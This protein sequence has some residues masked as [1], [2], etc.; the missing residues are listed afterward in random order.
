MHFSLFALFSS[1][2]YALS[3]TMN[4]TLSKKN[5]VL[6]LALW[7]SLISTVIGLPLLFTIYSNELSNLTWGNAVMSILISLVAVIAFPCF[8]AAFQKGSVVTTGIIANSYPAV[9]I[10]LSIFILGESPSAVQILAIMTI[11]IGVF[12]ASSPE[13]TS[14]FFK[15]L[16]KG[17]S[18]YA[19][20]TML[21]WGIYYSLIKFPVDEIGPFI[22]QYSAFVTMFVTFSIY[23]VF[24]R[25]KRAIKKPILLWLLTIDQVLA[26]VASLS[27]SYA[28]KAGPVSVVSPIAGSNP[29][30]FVIIA[31]ILFKEHLARK[32]WVGVITTISGILLIS[33]V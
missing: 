7:G 3:D 6:T 33:F 22:P 31:S 11:L 19:L 29:V 15:E 13:K 21:L 16:K 4:A 9:T 27:F 8:I 14:N 5:S 1:M 2:S 28:I 18:G 25:D 23:T 12:L 30:F 20:A 32:Q 24:K 10:L 17:G 26:Q